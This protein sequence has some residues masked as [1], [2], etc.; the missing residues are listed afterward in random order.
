[1]STTPDLPDAVTNGRMLKPIS[2]S[3]GKLSRVRWQKR[4][5]DELIVSSRN[6]L[7][8]QTESWEST[9]IG[10]IKLLV[11]LLE[12]HHPGY[13]S[14]KTGTLLTL[15]FSLIVAVVDETARDTRALQ[16]RWEIVSADFEGILGTVAYRRGTVIV[17]EADT[18]YFTDGFAKSQ[19]SK[20][21]LDA[22]AKPKSIDTRNDKGMRKTGI[23]GIYELDG[24]TLKLCLNLAGKRPKEFKT[25]AGDQTNLMILKRQKP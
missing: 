2:Y 19:G 3:T 14:M 7:L 25:S 1:V 24:D 8:R 20:F 4:P 5:A 10:T 11:R 13:A 9:S 17:V 23:T 15:L 16:G 12:S 18:L 6:G 22:K 21:K